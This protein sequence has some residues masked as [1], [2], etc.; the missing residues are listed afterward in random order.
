M[1]KFDIVLKNSKIKSYRFIAL[2]VILTN[3]AVF[4]FLLIADVHFFAAASAVFLVV[5]Y[6][7]YRF[8]L[9]KKYKTGFYMDEISIFILTGCWVVLQNYLLAF[10]CTLMG[11]LYYLSLQKIQFT[12]NAGSIKKMNFPIHEYSWSKF[13]NVLIRDNILTLDFTNNK[14][15]QAEIEN[16]QAINENEFNEFAKQCLMNHSGVEENLISE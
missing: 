15:L 5:L 11:V 13:T 16:A 3:L 8:Y 14:L 9:S 2:L 10:A 6:C 12:F 1:Q 7:F 4:I